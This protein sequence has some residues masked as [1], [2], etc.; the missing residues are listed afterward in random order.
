MTEPAVAHRS[1]RID[2]ALIWCDV[3]GHPAARGVLASHLREYAYEDK[4]LPIG[5]E[6]TI[7]QPYIVAFMT[8]ALGLSGGDKV[9]EIGAGSGYAA[10]VLSRI[11]G[12]VYTVERIGELAAKTSEKLSDLL[13]LLLPIESLA[14]FASRLTLIVFAFVNAS[15]IFAKIAADQRPPPAFRA[16]ANTTLGL[17]NEPGIAA[18]RTLVHQ[19]AGVSEKLTANQNGE[20]SSDEHLVRVAT[21][22]E[23]RNAAP[24]MRGHDDE[25]TAGLRHG[26]KNAIGDIAIGDMADNIV[27]THGSRPGGDSPQNLRGMIGTRAAVLAQ[28]GFILELGRNVG[29]PRLS[30]MNGNDAG[31]KLL[32]QRQSRG[33]GF[34]RQLRAV[35]S[36]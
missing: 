7:S 27:N 19:L 26:V 9:L 24:A 14:E 10:A 12:E 18:R 25:V 8:E 15:L 1:Q 5:E 16:P 17:G 21:H 28:E 3:T 36:N 31:L 23:A 20:V 34:V 6:Q 4:P 35:R 22:D 13:S 30:Y 29:R 2:G 33:H 32:S 11:A